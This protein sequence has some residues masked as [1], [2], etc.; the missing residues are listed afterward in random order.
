VT[1]QSIL[2]QMLQVT[3]GAIGAIFLD[4]EGEAVELW[5]EA[6]FDIGPEGLRAI[7]AYTGIFL[8]DL[9]RASGR[10]GA[11]N[12][13]QLTIDFE[14]AKVLSCGLKEGYYLVLVVAPGANEG[15]AAQRLRACRD[16]LNAEL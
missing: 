8:S 11:G 4:K 12:I 1:F 13:G 15:I 10:L 7:G 14:Q 6:V 3:P 16:R 5:A 9:H 2:Q